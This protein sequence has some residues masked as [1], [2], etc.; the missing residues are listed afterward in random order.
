LIADP[1]P[2]NDPHGAAAIY[3][4]SRAQGMV[5]NSGNK[6]SRL[7][8][9]RLKGEYANQFIVSAYIPHKHRKQAPF[10]EDTLEE[11]LQLIKSE[12][13]KGDCLIIMGDM[14]AKLARSVKGVTGKYCMHKK[15]DSGGERLTEIMQ[16]LN[17]SAA[18]TFF[19]PPRKAP[20][21]Q[22][23][24]RAKVKT[25]S[26][27]QIDYVLVSTRWLNSVRSCRVEWSHTLIRHLKLMDHGMVSV[28]MQMRVSAK[29]NKR[30]QLDRAWLCDKK[31]ATEFDKEYTQAKQAQ[32]VERSLD[33][34]YEQLTSFL[35]S[36]LKSVPPVKKIKKGARGCSQRTCDLV[37]ASISTLQGI[38]DGTPEY[39]A[40]KTLFQKQIATSCREDYREYMDGVLEDMEACDDRGDSKGVQKGVHLIA[41][42][43][44]KFCGKQ[45]TK[46]EKGKAIALPDEL[47]EA[48]KAFCERKFAWTEREESRDPAP[49]IPPAHT[50]KGDVPTD[51]ELEFCLAALAN[52]KCMGHDQVPIEAYRLSTQ[53]KGDLF[54]LIRRMWLEED[55]PSDLVLCELITIY[56]GKGSPDDF[57]KYRCLGMLTHGYKVLSCLLLK[58]MLEEVKDFLPESQAGFRKLRSTRDNILILA[59]LMDEVLLSQETCVITFI[60]FVAA[61]DSVSHKF[62]E[63]ALLEAGASEKSRAMFKAIYSKSTARIRL[64]TPGGEE[65]FSSPFPVDRGV[66]QGDI[67]SPLCFIVA[68]ESIMRKH[69]GA[70]SVTALGLLIDRL[71]YAD[72]AALIDANAEQASER[73]TRLYEGALQDADMEISAP[74]TEVMFCRPRVDTGE[75]TAEAYGEEELEAL[76]VRLDF[77][78]RHCGRGF[79]SHHGC[80]I[81]E[82]RHCKVA[83]LETFEEEFEIEEILEA[84]GSPE[85]RFYLVK[86]EGY[87]AEESTWEHHRNLESAEE[88]NSKVKEFLDSEVFPAL[89]AQLQA[90]VLRVDGE[91]RCPDC[92][93]DFR[94]DR[95]LKGHITKRCPLAVASRV[96]SRA[97]TAVAKARQVAVQEAAG[98]V[99]MGEHALINAFNFRYLGFHFQADGDRRPALLQRMAIARTR[100]GELHEA[101]R[102]KRMPTSM[103]LRLYACAV[104]SVLTYGSE[105]WR[106]DEKTKAKIRGWNARCLS[107]ITGRSI[108]D[109][110]VDP[111]FDMVSRLRSR[112]LRWAGHI[113]RLEESSLIRKVLIAVA[114]RE[115]ESGCKDDG[116]LL[117]DAPAFGSVEQLLEVAGDRD[118]WRVGVIGLLPATDPSVQQWERRQS[119]LDKEVARLYE[120]Q[121]EKD[122]VFRG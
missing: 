2:K 116:G 90:A 57:T 109:E 75:I 12:S 4:S 67:F 19:C 3:L 83:E 108:R 49:P 114:A 107:V 102:S 69:G 17:L 21:G 39:K 41:G 94:T 27:S 25:H 28:N 81:H 71:E 7:V 95:A 84:R 76:N 42:K 79:D 52:R 93:K 33:Q 59:N 117:A 15:T 62:L 86:W 103:K 26:P 82:E 20:L 68:L 111:S 46:D 110:T 119:K 78:C 23:T 87:D 38:R 91:N 53:A 104:V 113:L 8:W 97:E 14:N 96:G 99:T 105:I 13:V 50:R 98:K 51:E 9:V 31:N 44:K 10:Q 122:L 6:G 74:K 32:S 43:K 60:D 35:R 30:P 66:L 64:K 89:S 1:P 80:R 18:S 47:A 37:A 120:A 54:A 121:M 45:P 56:K 40:R 88:N 72:D 22:A 70:G 48:W 85:R 106:L 5:I 29:K 16:A 58:R 65:V 61:F 101:W 55:V 63:A 11:L 73:V 115:I 112:R 34:E 24:Y 92:N 36:A 77:K 100:F 118:E